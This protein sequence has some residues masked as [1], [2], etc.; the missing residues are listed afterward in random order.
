MTMLEG[1]LVIAKTREM[2]DL[3]R[4]LRAHGW[5]RDIHD[6]SAYLEEHRD[7]DPKF[8]FVNAGYNLRATELQAAMGLEQLRKLPHF[9]AVRRYVA[10]ALQRVFS[11]YQDVLQTQ[12]ECGQ[13]SWFGFPV[14]VKRTSPITAKQL[15]EHLENNGIETRSII[16]GNIA[17]QPAMKLWPHRVFGDLRH[18]DHVMRSGFSIGCHQGMGDEEVEHVR[19]VMRRMGV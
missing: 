13:S 9:L 8:L 5:V 3:L 7:I 16:C 11:Q 2:S 17:R 1:G 10:A 19:L 12:A 6:N 18:A 15:R 4:I 14:V